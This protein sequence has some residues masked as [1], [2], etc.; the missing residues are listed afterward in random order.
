MLFFKTVCLPL[1]HLNRELDA[2]WLLLVRGGDL[3]W[4]MRS[5]LRPDLVEGRSFLH[6]AAKPTQQQVRSTL[7]FCIATEGLGTSLHKKSCVDKNDL[8]GRK[9]GR[10]EGSERLFFFRTVGW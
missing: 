4:R 9:A 7:F 10:E 1:E 8:G 5:D 6:F 3:G 2:G